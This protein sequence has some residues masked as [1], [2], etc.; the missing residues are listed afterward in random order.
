MHIHAL[1]SHRPADSPIHRLDARVKT[2]LVILVILSTALT[3]DGAWREFLL[4]QA[5]LLTV[6]SLSRVGLGLVQ[7]RSAV[8][9]PFALAAVTVAF[10][11]PGGARAAQPLLTLRLPGG[12]WVVT[13]TGLLRFVCVL[14]RSYLSVQAGVILAATTAFPDLLWGARALRV[15]RILVAISSFLYR[16]LFILADQAQ[17]LMRAR[18]V[19]SAAI[20]GRGGGSV[21]WR[22]QVT[23]SMAGVLFLRSYERSE[24]VYASMLARGYDGEVHT[25]TPPGLR[26]GDVLWGALAGLFLLAVVVLGRVGR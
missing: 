17:R 6:A 22:A 8:A 12:S 10:S 25:L 13:D 5:F 14:V 18:E 7:K 16:Y 19:R 20:E 4:L 3:P 9:L 21:A 23:G 24:R 26:H 2:V 11:A 1:D 15:P